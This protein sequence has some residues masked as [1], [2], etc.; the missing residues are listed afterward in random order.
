MGE[1]IGIKAPN[2]TSMARRPG[3]M[4]TAVKRSRVRKLL[5]EMRFQLVQSLRK[6]LR[7]GAVMK[8]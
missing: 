3:E 1:S 5:P 6:S 4:N 7:L 2:L 8:L